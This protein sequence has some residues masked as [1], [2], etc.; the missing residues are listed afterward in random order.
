MGGWMVGQFAVYVDPHPLSR[1]L[2]A[3]VHSRSLA[4]C[5]WISVACSLALNESTSCRISSH[6]RSA[7]SQTSTSLSCV[8]V[9][10]LY[11]CMCVCAPPVRSCSIAASITLT[12]GITAILSNF[13]P[14][15]PAV[16]VT[17][18]HFTSAFASFNG[19]QCVISRS[20]RR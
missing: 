17:T 16:K 18:T 11:V 7:S 20:V 13:K 2:E 10:V 5:V 14:H 6:L 15:A 1:Q 4:V 19:V 3:S 9:C 12:T 8:H